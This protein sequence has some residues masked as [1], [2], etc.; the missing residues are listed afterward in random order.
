MRRLSIKN[1]SCIKD[2]SIDFGRLTVLIGPQASGKSVI[3]KLGYFFVDILSD[4][5]KFIFRNLNM[6]SFKDHIK[7]KF[8]E[9]FPP[10]AWGDGKF[11]IEFV[12]GDFKISLVRTSYRAKVRDLFRIKLS[13]EFEKN[14]AEMRTHAAKILSQKKIKMDY[15]FEGEWAV[16]DVVSKSTSSLLGKDYLASQMFIPAGRSFF[17]SIGKAIAAFEQGR[18]LDP[19]I[20]RFGRIF[21]SHKDAPLFYRNEEQRALSNSISEALAEI[22]GGT[23]NLTGDQEVVEC[24]DGRK[25]P[26]SALSSGQQEILPLVAVLPHMAYRG[27]RQCVYIE[28]PEAHLFPSAQSKLVELF[29]KFINI[30]GTGADLVITTHSPYVLVKINNLIKA[31]QLGRLGNGRNKLKVDEVISRSA[32]IGHKYVKAYAIRDG[33]LEDIVDADGFIDADYLDEISGE[34]SKEFLKLL[35]IEVGK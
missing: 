7:T 31:G 20:V 11:Q 27:T 17:T 28:E 18:V 33:I 32:W 8:C 15:I 25:I 23:L 16:S 30:S 34:L 10:S 24:A 19:L 21:T 4:Q 2:A 12:A 5:N 26:L 3:C 14:F 6:D 13:E 1:F 29:S 35:A 9:W 22:L